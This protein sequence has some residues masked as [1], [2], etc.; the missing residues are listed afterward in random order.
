M[1][2]RHA[3]AG[4]VVS[5]LAATAAHAEAVK[6]E[7]TVTDL[8]G[9]RVVVDAAGGKKLV[10]FGPK[11][12]GLKGLKA[13]DKIT[14]EGDLKKSGEVRALSVK[15]SDGTDVVIAKDHQTWR[16]WLLGDDGDDKPFTEAEA[17]KIATDKGYQL[18]GDLV[19]EKR[20]FVATATKDGKTV[21]VDVHR[22]GTIKEAATF[23]V[24]GASAAIAKA[25][26]TVVGE[27]LPVK[28]H[29]EALAKKDDKFFEVH[30]RR[31]G[32]VDEIKSVDKTDPKWGSQIQ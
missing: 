7:G 1:T 23:D 26:Y 28:K 30:A 10:N 12:E 15:L 6:I 31:D 25:G 27:A 32:S 20:H 14:I 17:K 16:E 18:T 5:M 2:F 9:H 24:A 29:F 21:E 13:G 4:A 3:A 11:I 8:F 19:A 22:D